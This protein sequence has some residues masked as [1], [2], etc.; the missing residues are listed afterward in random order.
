MSD[1]ELLELEYHWSDE[2]EYLKMAEC[3]S[4]LTS[5]AYYF[6]S[7]WYLCERKLTLKPIFDHWIGL[8]HG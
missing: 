5:E 4:I 7:Q 1:D 6:I 3:H 2:I 8:N